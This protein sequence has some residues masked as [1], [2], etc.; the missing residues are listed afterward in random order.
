[1]MIVINKKKLKKVIIGLIAVILIV[2][3]GLYLMKRET[4]PTLNLDVANQ[5]YYQGTKVKVDTLH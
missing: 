2:I 5:P 1:M 4:K 3:S